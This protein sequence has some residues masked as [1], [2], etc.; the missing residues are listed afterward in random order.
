M[1]LESFSAVDDGF[2]D[3]IRDDGIFGAIAVRNEAF[4]L[5]GHCFSS[6]AFGN[7]TDKGGEFSAAFSII[8]RDRVGVPRAREEGFEHIDNWGV[9]QLEGGILRLGEGRRCLGAIFQFVDV[10]GVLAEMTVS[11]VQSLVVLESLRH[12]IFENFT[13]T[14]LDDVVGQFV[15]DLHVILINCEEEVGTKKHSE[16][17]KLY[18]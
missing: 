4:H 2:F 7:F 15:G 3:E 17:C 1:L 18:Q 12:S 14:V 5:R 9:H 10:I 11:H 8:E 16:P 6:I 13:A